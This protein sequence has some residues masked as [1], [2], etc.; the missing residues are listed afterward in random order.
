M[1]S[2]VQQADAMDTDAEP[3]TITTQ[4][5][6]AVDASPEDW[7]LQVPFFITHVFTPTQYGVKVQGVLGNPLAFLGDRTSGKSFV[8]GDADEA[9]K[10]TSHPLWTIGTGA[11]EGSLLV[12]YMRWGEAGVKDSNKY[13]PLFSLPS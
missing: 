2:S 6:T 1:G 3:T 10:G 7:G 13:H 5:P 11:D 8:S 9:V 4:M 12:H